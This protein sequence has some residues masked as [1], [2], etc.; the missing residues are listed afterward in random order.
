MGVIEKIKSLRKSETPGEIEK[1][2]LSGELGKIWTSSERYQYIE[3]I[4]LSWLV[5]EVHEPEF[6]EWMQAHQWK[7]VVHHTD[8]NPLNNVYLNLRV[9]KRS[10]HIKLHF[11][12]PKFTKNVEQRNEKISVSMKAYHADPANVKD[13]EARGKKI[14]A[15]LANPVNAK[16][17]EVRHKKLSKTLRK[18][19]V[20]LLAFESLFT[21]KDYATVSKICL[22][23]AY[24]RLESLC[25]SGEIVCKRELIG[26]Y[27]QNTYS[28]ER[29]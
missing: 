2:L 5:V 18:Y 4:A 14:S 11:S 27:W 24:Y 28:I 9:M 15:Y 8:G 29:R 3:T 7:Y 20:D 22:A 1:A 25:R 6:I 23:T 13:I 21:V 12:D 16:D 19:W 17:I 26:S 10:E